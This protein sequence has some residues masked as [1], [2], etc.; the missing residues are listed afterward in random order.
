MTIK[1]TRKYYSGKKKIHTL[2]NQFRA[3][4]GVEDIVYIYIGQL[5][6]I[7]DITLFINDRHNLDAK[8]RFLGDKAYIGEESITTPYLITIPKKL[9]PSEI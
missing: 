8:Q 1:S 4:L 3:L 5:G 6:R 2:K 9:K 7:S